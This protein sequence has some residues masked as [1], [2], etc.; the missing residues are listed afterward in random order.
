MNKECVISEPFKREHKRKYQCSSQCHLSA[1]DLPTDAWR[2]RISELEQQTDEL[3]QQL[4]ASARA[5]STALS[6]SSWAAA[7]DTRPSVN[8]DTDTR[9][10]SV[11]P[12]FRHDLI[13]P[14]SFRS[15]PAVATESLQTPESM[16]QEFQPVDTLARSLDGH[17]LDPRDIDGLFQLYALARRSLSHA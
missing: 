10:A 5:N 6:G 3:H 4:R 16:P 2:R 15:F 7:N 17:T 12:F 9:L 13:A 14:V 1:K 8:A 11:A